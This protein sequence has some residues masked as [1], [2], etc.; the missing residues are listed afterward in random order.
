MQDFMSRFFEISESASPLLVELLRLLH[1]QCKSCSSLGLLSFIR[2][3]EEGH[4]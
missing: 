4:G 2:T 1:V 3:L